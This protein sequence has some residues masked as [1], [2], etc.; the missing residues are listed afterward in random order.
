MGTSTKYPK[1]QKVDSRILKK[2]EIALEAKGWKPVHL[3]RALGFSDTWSHNL[4]KGKRGLD[5]SMLIQI[6]EKLEVD[7]SSLLPDSLKEGP[8]RSFEEYIESIM[9]DV[10]EK[11]I[12][13]LIK[14][15]FIKNKE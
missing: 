4:M 15:E 14:K 13:P 5:I 12:I 3:G 9:M 1:Q 2:I 8:P 11:K 10:F 7:P 6:A